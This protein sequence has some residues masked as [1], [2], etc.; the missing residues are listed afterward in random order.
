MFSMYFREARHT[1]TG[2]LPGAASPARAAKLP[3]KLAA[4]N[5]ASLPWQRRLSPPT[6]AGAHRVVSAKL[7]SLIVH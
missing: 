5:Y 7:Y 4:T 3:A 6:R 1:F 2:R